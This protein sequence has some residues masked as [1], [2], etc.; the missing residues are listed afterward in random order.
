M[1]ILYTVPTLFGLEGIC[2]KELKNLGIKNV[3]AQNG[4]VYFKGDFTDGIR[5]N[6]NLRTAE[7]VLMVISEFEALDFETLYQNVK[8]INWQDYIP[9]KGAF[10]VKGF[11]LNSALH[12][13]PDCQKIIKKAV[14]DKLSQVYFQE[15]F[16]ESEEKYQIQFSIMKNKVSIMLDMSGDSLHKRGYRRNANAAPLRETLAAAI[17]ILSRFGYFEPFYDPMCGSGTIA[18]EAALY[19]KNIAPGINRDFSAMH[20]GFVDERLWQDELERA[21]SKIMNKDYKIYASD[22]DPECVRLTAENAKKAGVGDIVK[23]ARRDIAKITPMEESGTIAINPPYGKR[24]L[25]IKQARELYDV[26]GRKMREFQGWSKYIICSDEDFEK[27]YKKRADKKRK[28]Y[29]GMIK[30]DLFE[31]F[32]K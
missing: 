14:V 24:M 32:K 8:K 16:E 2:A 4:R 10:P 12:S 9:K 3:D 18:I 31:Y 20:W 19:A 5:A 29:N 23:V 7:R 15:W 6:I 28:L 30:C 11:S 25:E 1:E 27:F 13:V 26:I 21:K 22:I 17:V